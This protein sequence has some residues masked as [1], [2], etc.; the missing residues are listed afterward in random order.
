M[1][2]K[3][4]KT[5]EEEALEKANLT[6]V[7]NSLKA[8]AAER[9][10]KERAE[11][12]AKDAVSKL[13][14]SLK[15]TAQPVPDPTS[16]KAT[17]EQASSSTKEAVVSGPRGTGIEPEFYMKQYLATINGIIN[18][19]YKLSKHLEIQNLAKELKVIIWATIHRDGSL[20]NIELI[21]RSNNMSFNKSTLKAVEA[22]NPLPP[23]PSQLKE[24]TLEVGF[25][26]RPEGLY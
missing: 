16:A 23:L 1:K 26:F 13:A 6:R 12:A 10:A 19:H 5:I 18:D 22:A 3:L 14:D 25:R 8:K 7:M 4:G 24:E 11:K 20:T 9:E 2:L 15:A 17:T 21:E